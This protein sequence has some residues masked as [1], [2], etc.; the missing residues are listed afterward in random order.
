MKSCGEFV[1]CRIFKKISNFII[2]SLERGF[3]QLG[4]LVAR[5]P[6]A[7]IAIDLIL[8]AAIIPGVVMLKQENRTDKLWVP[9]GSIAQL[10]KEWVDEKFPSKIRFSN[11]IFENDD[12]V[13]TP[14][15]IKD[16]LKFD[17][18]VKAIR[19][20]NQYNWQSICARNGD[21]CWS[22]SILELWKFDESI[23]NNLSK[24]QI[25][26][27]INTIT[28]S[29]VYNSP[30]TA[31]KLLGDINREGGRI[32]SAKATRVTYFIKFNSTVKNGQDVDEIGDSWEKSYLD[33]A[34]K[35]SQ[36]PK[37]NLYYFSTRSFGD[38]GGGAISGDVSLLAAGYMIVI[39]F[40][41]IVLGKFN[42]VE[43]RAWVTLSGIGCIGLAIGI[44][45]GFCSYIRLFYGPLHSVLPFLLLGIG[46][47]DMFV[48]IQAWESL[49]E[50]EKHKSVQEKIGCML[51][52]AGV[53]ITVTSIT[54]I[55]AFGVG[56]STII[57]ALRSFCIWVCVGV[58]FTFLFQ[59]TLFVAC[60]SFDQRRSKS[61]R[62][63]CCCCIRYNDFKPNACSQKSYM[64]L[65]FSKIYSKFILSLPVKII[66]IVI[67]AA[68]FGLSI[69]RVTELE[70]DFDPFLFLPTGTY[71]RTFVQ[72]SD[73][74][75]PEAGIN[76]A[77][78]FDSEKL[79]YF[80]KFTRLE[81]IHDEIEG[82]PY[83]SKGT[84][85]SWT[86]SYKEFLKNTNNP[87]IIAKLDSNKF[88]KTKKDFDEILFKYFIVYGGN[89]PGNR[90]IKDIK[91]RENTKTEIIEAFRFTFTHRQ[92]SN[93][94]E[95][96][97]AMDS[98]REV[99]NKAS[100]DLKVEV[101]V[102]ENS[103]TTFEGNKVS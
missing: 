92:L 40:V 11:G 32:V 38:V 63:A 29:P 64:N 44:S 88:P 71:A 10:D 65:F 46:V 57:P 95:E 28:I 78:Y 79:N 49:E 77:V 39:V 13:L 94:A 59:I 42:R 53:S 16:M 85:D 45:F 62:D 102:F 31:S 81:K 93:S 26:N 14:E 96:I 48:I 76:S 98:I 21:K 7:F 17:K 22:N 52:H 15:L 99:A 37:T 33:I 80:E 35:G 5:Y 66:I 51:K 89:G 86:K 90:F 56:A 47:D 50:E 101:R 91:L 24:E 87:D 6:W 84:T 97:K 73:K 1:I 55:V 61:E 70:Q 25:L 4:C 34:E 36:L 41:C 58:I 75:F 30:F 69:W 8:C 68:L 83:T 74:Y 20:D 54:D 27:D 18:K 2:N 19:K 72:K 103:Y 100:N 3:Y 23:I 60:I 12:D 82:D 9:Q 43:Q 67:T